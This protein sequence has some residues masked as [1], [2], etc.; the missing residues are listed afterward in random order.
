[1]ELIRKINIKEYETRFPNNNETYF[2]NLD[3]NQKEKYLELYSVYLSMLLKYLDYKC[4]LKFFDEIILNDEMKFKAISE[5][6]MD[7][8]QY[9]CSNLLKYFYIRSNIYIERLSKEEIEFLKIQNLNFNDKNSYQIEN[10]ICN[11][12]SK[13][14]FETKDSNEIFYTN[15]GPDSKNFIKPNNALI[16]GVRFDDYYIRED[17]SQ[18]TWVNNNNIR[19]SRLIAISEMVEDS[20][21]ITLKIPVYVIKY[22]DFSIKKKIEYDNQNTMTK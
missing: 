19:L 10:F 21:S 4:S 17:E 3:E 2:N 11:T 1:M 9:S 22:N 14:I 18:E 12:L 16:L 15:Y 8:Y 20:L 7:L 5:E 13:V 6:N